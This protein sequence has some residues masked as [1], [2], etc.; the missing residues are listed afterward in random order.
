MMRKGFAA[1][2]IVA[3]LLLGVALVSAQIVPEDDFTMTVRV[4]SAFVRAAPSLDAEVVASLFDDDRLEAVGRN[5]DGLWFQVRRLGRMNNIG[6]V[7]NEVVSWDFLPENL[8]LTEFETGRTGPALLTTDPGFAAFMEDNANL[9]TEPALTGEILTVVPVGSTVPVLERNQDGTWLRVH[10]LGTEGWIAEFT[11]RKFANVFDLALAEGLP[12]LKTFAI[13]II[14]PEVQLAQLQRLRDF[15]TNSRALSDQLASYWLTVQRG[16]TMPC[17]PPAFV[18]EYMATAQD[19]RELPE[20]DRYLPQVTDGIFN[21]NVAIEL[22]Y[23]CG[24]FNPDVVQRA[25]N[26]AINARVI[27]DANLERLDNLEENIIIIE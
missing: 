11:V 21:L 22:L 8:P 14:P 20:L 5:L 15:M 1:V 6:W 9:R 3:M 2:L 17:A 24:T 23:I 25:R 4:E 16:E 18:E 19:I 10:Y 13:L 26:G 27:F 7:F 12:P